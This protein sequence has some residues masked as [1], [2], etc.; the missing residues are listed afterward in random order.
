LEEMGVLIITHD[1]SLAHWCAD[2]IISLA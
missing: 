1:E 2:E